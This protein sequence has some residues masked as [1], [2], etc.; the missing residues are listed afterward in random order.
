MPQSPSDLLALTGF[1]ASGDGTETT[2]GVMSQAISGSQVD[3]QAL[4]TRYVATNNKILE[5]KQVAEAL[6]ELEATIAD[7]EAQGCAEA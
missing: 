6:M 4:A 1:P 7:L 5:W 2:S 3:L